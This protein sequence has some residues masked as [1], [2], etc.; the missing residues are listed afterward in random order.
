[1]AVPA[2]LPVAATGAAPERVGC[3][4]RRQIAYAVSV[5]VDFRM[6][7]V[8]TGDTDTKRNM[9]VGTR[10]GRPPRVLSAPARCPSTKDEPGLWVEPLARSCPHAFIVPRP[11][12]IRH[13]VQRAHLLGDSSPRL[14]KEHIVIDID[15]NTDGLP[16]IEQLRVIVGAAMTVGLILAVLALIIS[17]VVWG[18]GANSSNPHLASRGKVGVLVSCGA[19]IICGASVTL[20][21]FFWNVGQSV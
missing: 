9:G 5:V 17:A 2:M 11:A 18:Y 7:D 12:D 4:G 6:A 20:V 14:L 8:T 16:G 10:H 21:N 1:M 13:P 15:P 3:K 19:A